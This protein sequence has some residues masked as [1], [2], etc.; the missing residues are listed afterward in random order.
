MRRRV[1]RDQA[2]LV[3]FAGPTRS[4][5][6][7]DFRPDESIVVQQGLVTNEEPFAGGADFGGNARSAQA[8]VDR[9]ERLAPYPFDET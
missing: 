3:R 1:A 9:R 8:L 5:L 4:Q 2:C 6:D 7:N